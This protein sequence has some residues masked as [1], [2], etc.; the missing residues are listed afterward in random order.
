[1]LRFP[2]FPLSC[3]VALAALL[4]CAKDLKSLTPFPCASDGTCPSG[5]TCNSGQCND[6]P[7]CYGPETGCFPTCQG[8]GLASSTCLSCL[9]KSC[10]SQLADVLAT[11]GSLFSCYAECSCDGDSGCIAQC[12]SSANG[13]PCGAAYTS[14]FNVCLQQSD[15]AP[16][17]DEGSG[18]A[19][20]SGGDGTTSGEGFTSSSGVGLTSSGVG[21]TS[22]GIGLTSSG[23][24]FT[25]SGF[26]T[27]G[28]G[29]TGGATAG[30]SSGSTGSSTSSGVGAPLPLS[31]CSG[32]YSCTETGMAGSLSSTLSNSAGVCTW[33]V[34]DTSLTISPS[35]QVL[36]NGANEGN[37]AGSSSEF[38]VKIGGPDAGPGNTVLCI[39][40]P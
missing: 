25:S 3:A 9:S 40:T 30:G 18:S 38:S 19:T 10:D 23:T 16:E 11:C 24:G 1:M 17:C 34:V 33:T 22:S 7:S 36:L 31:P 5:F 32:T 27:G 28:G 26:T 15:C 12:Q 13:T 39:E 6:A 8:P 37:W 21:L 2:L 14:L 4:A 35:G 29:S 20:S